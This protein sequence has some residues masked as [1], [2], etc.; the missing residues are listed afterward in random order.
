MSAVWLGALAFLMALGFDLASLGGRSTLKRT[1]L[2]VAA[3]LFFIA[4][5]QILQQP[6]LFSVPS[7]IVATGI[8]LSLLGLVLS[9]YSLAI[10]IPAR[11]TYLAADAADQLITTGTYALTRHPGVLWFA[12]L[13]LGLVIANRSAVILVAAPVWLGLDL[14]YVWI[15]DRFLFPRQFPDY[16]H[17]RQQTPMLIPTARSIRRCW[18]TFRC[19]ASSPA[20]PD[21]SLMRAEIGEQK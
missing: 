12:L 8:L 3:L 13:L 5:Y 15:Q 19:S 18:R 1:M 9:V 14:F 4:F 6:P 7:W 10:E 20:A 16:E 21:Q 2:A 17:Y 11:R